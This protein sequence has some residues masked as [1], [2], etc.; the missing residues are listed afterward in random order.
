M[1]ELPRS[2]RLTREELLL[3]QQ[4]ALRQWRGSDWLAQHEPREWLDLPSRVSDVCVDLGS[5]N[6]EAE[7]KPGYIALD[8]ESRD[9]YRLRERTGEARSVDIV[10][11]LVYGLPFDDRT[12]D[13]YHVRNLLRGLERVALEQL[14]RELARTL[15]TGGTVSV[16]DDM[17]L[18]EDFGRRLEDVG[19]SLEHAGTEERGTLKATFEL[20]TQK[21]PI[22]DQVTPQIDHRAYA[23]AKVR[24][25]MP[26]Y[27]KPRPE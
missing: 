15:R 14:P 8:R 20:S 4:R 21:T 1:S 19:F 24:E 17:R 7:Q 12:V 18:V 27:P 23:D 6:G 13:H 10:W 26:P 2:D 9:P 25:T 3:L 11:D 22:E 16:G 5:G